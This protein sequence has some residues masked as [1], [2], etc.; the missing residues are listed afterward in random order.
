MSRAATMQRRLV[1][2]NLH[3]RPRVM[4]SG[5]F[6]LLHSGHIAFLEEAATLGRLHVAIGS[7]KTILKL[8]GK[9]PINSESERLY[10]VKSLRCV[11]E[12]FISSGTGL[13]DFAPEIDRVSPDL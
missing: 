4:V 1:V 10:I 2:R 6:D 13:F 3:A 11:D 7:D 12:A 9:P 5:C 8:K